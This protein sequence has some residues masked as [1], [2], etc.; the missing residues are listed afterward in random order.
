MEIDK[1][2]QRQRDFYRTGRTKD[3]AFR[4]A[5]LQKLADTIEKYEA[6]IG[7]ALKAD[8]HKSVFEGFMTE[9]GLTLS[10]IRFLIKHTAVWNRPKKVRTPLAQ[11]HAKSYIV[12]EPY[13]VALVMSPWN[14]PFMLSLEPAA[15]AIAAGNCCII[16]PSAYAPATSAI[17]KKII[18][19]AF[20]APAAVCFPVFR[21][22]QQPHIPQ[23]RLPL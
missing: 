5:S 4:I 9:V 19:E 10:E 6:E 14:Y 15:G 16:K 1:L 21:L 7:E 2:V 17:L 13:G 22:P 8:L 23:E 18:E 11:F 12:Q 20:P 3:T